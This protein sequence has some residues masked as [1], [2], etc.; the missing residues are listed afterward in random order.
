M[1]AYFPSFPSRRD[2]VSTTGG[3]MIRQWGKSTGY[4][5]SLSSRRLDPQ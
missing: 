4:V 3:S 5:S 2:V 1:A